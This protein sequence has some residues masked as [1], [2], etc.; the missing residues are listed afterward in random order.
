ML[1]SYFLLYA[2]L[3]IYFANKWLIDWL[4]DWI[5]QSDSSKLAFGFQKKMTKTQRYK[6]MFVQFHVVSES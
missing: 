3:F 2:Y 1:F 6:I 4:I 5:V